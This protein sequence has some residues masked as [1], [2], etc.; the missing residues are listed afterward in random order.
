MTTVI[1]PEP[2]ENGIVKFD[3]TEQAISELQQQYMQLKIVD[4]HDRQGEKAVHDARMVI[5]RKRILIEARIKELNQKAQDE[6]KKN[7]ND[8]NFLIDLLAPIEKHLEGEEKRIEQQREALKKE[9]E[10]R[11][12]IRIQDRINKISAFGYAIDLN[13]IRL[14]TDIA[15]ADLLEQARIEYEKDLAVK[16]EARRLAEEEAVRIAAERL[17]LAELRQQQALIAKE[18]AARL[19]AIQDA[20]KAERLAKL[21]AERKAALLPDKEKI[22]A[23]AKVLN[24]LN[25]PDVKDKDAQ[26]LITHS[27]I[28][29]EHL[30]ADIIVWLNETLT[31]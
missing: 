11:E 4:V 25:Y 21:A 29:I 17:E 14:M 2:R 9:A 31:S 8:G 23:F 30:I 13:E 15:F 20:E 10:A 12:T 26:E 27:K 18:E 19:K 22:Q 5:K 6:I 1:L 28:K 16:A 3:L 24:E 7:K